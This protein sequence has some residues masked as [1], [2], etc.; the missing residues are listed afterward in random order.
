MGLPHV[1]QNNA[2]GSFS[3]PQTAHFTMSPEV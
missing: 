1:P 2:W 3:E